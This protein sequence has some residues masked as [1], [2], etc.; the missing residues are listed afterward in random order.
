M[1]PLLMLAALLAADPNPEQ[2][3]LLKVFRDEFIAVEPGKAPYPEHFL[4]GRKTGGTDRERPVQ[5]VTFKRGFHIAKYEVPQN[6]WEA[7]MGN[8][9]SRWKGPRNSVEMLSLDEAKQFCEK[10]TEL[11]RAAKLITP[12]QV[13]RL[14]S[15]AEWE[16][17]ARAGTETVYSFGDDPEKLGQYAW[18][19]GNAAGNDPPV[20]AKKPN[21]W[22]LYDVHGYLW[23]W[24]ADAANKDY[25]D[26][27]T[28]GTARTQGDQPDA[29]VVRGG[30]WKDPADRLTSSFRLIVPKN[31][32][33]D[34]VGLR[35]VLSDVEKDGQE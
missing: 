10:A 31:L 15:E 33:D 3:K 23:E 20:G 5:K 21:Q 25:T 29:G 27:P 6:L 2:Q 19:T 11:M 26:A 34:A 30:S 35:C 18:F 17:A 16:Y 14:P 22:G 24:C 1:S 8:N 28:D 32:R 9:P 13:I 7:V 4:M 12:S